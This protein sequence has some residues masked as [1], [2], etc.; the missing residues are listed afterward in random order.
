MTGVFWQVATAGQ[1]DR[2]DFAN[3]AVS[4]LDDTSGAPLLAMTSSDHE[5]VKAWLKTQ[6]APMGD[7]PSKLG[8]VPSVGCQKYVIHG[9]TV[10][11]ICFELPSGGVVH[12]FTVE[13]SALSD[14][15]SSQGP[16]FDKL[17]NWNV[18]SWSDSKMS[19]M[20]VTTVSMDDL[21]QLL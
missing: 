10:S 3:A 15:P 7:L 17:K 16:H 1:L 11:L 18:A 19:Y 13:K 4:N 2:A 5:M 12:L 9:H 8:S 21:K 6:S 14:P 20:L